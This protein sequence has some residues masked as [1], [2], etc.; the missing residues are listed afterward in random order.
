[1]SVIPVAWLDIIN[2]WAAGIADIEKVYVFG[3]Y[4]RGQQTNDSD[5]DLGVI[6][7]SSHQSEDNYTRWAFESDSWKEKLQSQLSVSLD[8]ELG[9]P[10][11]S[12][13][14]V[15]PAIQDH[16]ILLYDAGKDKD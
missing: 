2:E 12:T 14:I 4:A 9:N 11:I 15:G 6:V 7:K 5:L 13:K 3:S 8:L 16:G 10:E 1:M